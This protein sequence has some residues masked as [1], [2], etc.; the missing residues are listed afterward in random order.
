MISDWSECLDSLERTHQ[1][2]PRRTLFGHLRTHFSGAMAIL[3][4]TVVERATALYGSRAW[5]T[6]I[7]DRPGLNHA[8]SITEKLLMKGPAIRGSFNMA[9]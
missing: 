2:R 4:A 6:R 5:I 3:G 1:K 9:L 7:I 8:R